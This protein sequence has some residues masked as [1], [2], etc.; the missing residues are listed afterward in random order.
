MK[1]S[2]TQYLLISAVIILVCSVAMSTTLTA[3]LV[4]TDKAL[5]LTLTFRE[6]TSFDMF[7]YYYTN[8]SCWI[9]LISILPQVYEDDVF[10]T[11][12]EWERINKKAILDTEVVDKVSDV[13]VDA[14]LKLNGVW[15]GKLSY[16]RVVE[17]LLQYYSNQ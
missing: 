17:L 9:P 8:L 4:N 14:N 13:F 10:V 3:F 5:M 11:Q 2:R 15:D 6:H 1:I 16:S 7:W 12:E